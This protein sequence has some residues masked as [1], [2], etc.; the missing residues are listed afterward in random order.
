MTIL[1][2]SL[3]HRTHQ[4]DRV[5][6]GVF[7]T[8]WSACWLY[9]HLWGVDVLLSY[10]RHD[11]VMSNYITKV[12]RCAPKKLLNFGAR[13]LSMK[14]LSMETTSDN[15]FCF[16][17]YYR[18]LLGVIINLHRRIS[19]INYFC[20]LSRLLSLFNLSRYNAYA[21]TQGGECQGVR[22]PA[23]SDFLNFT[24][25]STIDACLV[26]VAAVLRRR[27]FQWMNTCLLR[28]IWWYTCMSY[29]KSRYGQSRSLQLVGVVNLTVV[30][31]ILCQMSGM[32]EWDW[33]YMAGSMPDRPRICLCTF[34]TA[35]TIS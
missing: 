25:W 28:L 4:F 24:Y 32:S 16:R 34:S 2:Q 13:H 10:S 7:L 30:P 17:V 31:G 12:N 8:D 5:F 6:D 26:H 33:S 21:C 22:S 15:L 18:S 27:T 11:T 29:C 19:L 23:K 1:K 14:L 35:N 20:N 3:E 9:S